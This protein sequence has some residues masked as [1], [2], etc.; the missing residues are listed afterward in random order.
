[1]WAQIVRLQVSE[2]LLLPCLIES[3][4]VLMIRLRLFAK[5][6]LTLLTFQPSSIHPPTICAGNASEIECMTWQF[7]S[8]MN[9]R[10]F[11][12]V[13]IVANL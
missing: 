6:T 13:N 5:E 11:R 1:M 9:Q 12:N 7:H 4:T 3:K 10:T 2:S 8:Q